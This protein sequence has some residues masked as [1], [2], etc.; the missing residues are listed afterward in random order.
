MDVRSWFF[1]W[2]DRH[3]SRNPHNGWTAFEASGGPLLSLGWIRALSDMEVTEAEADSASEIMQRGGEVWP[4]DHLPKLLAILSPMVASR[5][6]ERDVQRRREAV[7][8]WGREVDEFLASKSEWSDL[9]EDERA[10]REASILARYP[11]F[12][13]IPRFALRFAI[14]E[15]RGLELPDPMPCP[16]PSTASEPAPRLGRS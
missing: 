3:K 12:R 15:W 5:R 10:R 11:S 8:R 13:S 4:V 2:F 9:P 1:G 6:A 16:S 14:D 7:E